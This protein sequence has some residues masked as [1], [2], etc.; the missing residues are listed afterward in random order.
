MA[1]QAGREAED[2]L[3][4]QAPGWT[5]RVWRLACRSWHSSAG[6]AWARPSPAPVAWS[7]TASPPYAGSSAYYRG[8]CRQLQRRRQGRPAGRARRGH[9]APRCGLRAGGGGHGRGRPRRASAAT[10][11]VAVTGVAGPEWRQRGQAGGSD[12]RGRG[13]SRWATRCERHL[14]DGDRAANKERSAAAALELLL[15][16]IEARRGSVV[17]R[18]A[19]DVARGLA[20]ARAA[21]AIAPGERIHVIGAAGAGASAAAL[22]AHEAGGAPDG[23]DPG[24]P[25]PYT[26]ALDARAI[27]VVTE[28]DA[29]HVVTEAPPARLA[30]TKAL[31]SVQPDHPELRGRARGRGPHRGLAADRG[32]R[33]GEPGR[34]RW[35]PWPARTASRPRPAGWCTCSWRPARPGAPS[36]ARCCRR[37]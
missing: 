34:A 27:A 5:C 4:S 21:R 32:R 9:R 1:H 25:S 19:A 7:A 23:C 36:W 14:W 37:R 26:A 30:V 2:Q 11:R 29:A 13:R 17:I 31:T 33:G 6:S 20:P 35:W 3:L 10:T 16:L 24:A 28:H 12:L 22:L 18:G 8:R 15:R